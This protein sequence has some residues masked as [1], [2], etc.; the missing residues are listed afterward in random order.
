MRALNGARASASNRLRRLLPPD[1][2]AVG[3]ALILAERDD[4]PGSLRSRFAEAGLAHLLAISGL[5]VGLIGVTVSM[6]LGLLMKP[7]RAAICSAMVV[8]LYVAAIGAPASAVRAALL[9]SGWAAARARGR[10]ARSWDLL[11]AAAILALVADPLV[12]GEA[13]FQLSFA[14]FIGLGAGITV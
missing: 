8:A 12:L 7:G 11:G 4:I 14:G 3:R 1:A 2:S 6:L 9:L 5:H 10:P 13:G